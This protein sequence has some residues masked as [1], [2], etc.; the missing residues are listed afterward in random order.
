[1]TDRFP[2]RDN[3]S[4]RSQDN[5]RVMHHRRQDFLVVIDPAEGIGFTESLQ[6]AA[7]GFVANPP[8]A[9]QSDILAHLVH[10]HIRDFAPREA[11]RLQALHQTGDESLQFAGVCYYAQALIGDKQTG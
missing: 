11:A 10:P 4:I 9:H 2:P 1:M 5:L 6:F 7:V 8:N 3:V